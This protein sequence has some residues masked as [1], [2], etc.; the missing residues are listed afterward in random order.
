M[1]VV[2]ADENVVKE[3]YFYNYGIDID[4]EDLEL[5]EFSKRSFF[6]QENK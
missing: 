5:E 2:G 1:L 4:E 3:Y 6:L